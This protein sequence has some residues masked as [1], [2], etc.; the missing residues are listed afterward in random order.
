MELGTSPDGVRVLNDAYNANPT[1]V[2]A[3]LESLAA[4]RPGGGSPCWA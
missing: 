4:C 2:L 1:S 3:A